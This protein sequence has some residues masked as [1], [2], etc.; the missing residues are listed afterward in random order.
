MENREIVDGGPDLT[1]V[2]G[3]LS[4]QETDCLVCFRGRQDTEQL[5]E[6][7]RAYGLLTATI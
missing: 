3:Q 2:N 1:N 5:P 4:L 6:T 7:N